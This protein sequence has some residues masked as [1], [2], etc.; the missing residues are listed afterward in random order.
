M[1]EGSPKVQ[2]SSYNINNRDIM[3]NMINIINTDTLYVKVVW[4]V[5]P[6]SSYHTHKIFFFVLFCI[7]M[8]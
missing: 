1:D 2:T 8:R 4:R 6:E 7:Y 3:Y 5:N